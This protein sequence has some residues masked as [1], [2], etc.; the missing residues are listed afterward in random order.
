M[1]LA[2]PVNGCRPAGKLFK[3]SDVK[4]REREIVIEFHLTVYSKHSVL[5]EDLTQTHTHMH[6]NLDSSENLYSII[7]FP[8]VTVTWCVLVTCFCIQ[9]YL[10]TCGSLPAVNVGYEANNIHSNDLKM[11]VTNLDSLCLH[12]L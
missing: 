10:S 11:R 3:V 12:A 2:S 4:A 8:C 6:T 7:I 1:T 5:P 9:P